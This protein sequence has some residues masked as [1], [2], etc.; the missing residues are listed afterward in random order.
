MKRFRIA[1]IYWIVALTLFTPCAV[2]AYIDPATTTYI[3][4]IITALVVTIGV[5]LSVFLY[6]FRMISS[7]IR[8]GIYG[9]FN[10]RRIDRAPKSLSPVGN[11]DKEE[12]LVGYIFPE[13]AIPGA[14]NPPTVEAMEAL[15]EPTDM[16]KADKKETRHEPEKGNYRKRLL[17]A[18]P[19]SAAIALSFV[20][21]S[22]MDLV[23]ENP[24]DI[25]FKLSAILPTLILVTLVCFAVLLF[26]IPL[27]R[28]WLYLIVVSVAVAILISGYIQGNF[29]NRGLNELTGDA[30]DWGLQK[31]LTVESVIFWV[32][33]LV[34]ILLLAHFLKPAMRVLYI[35]I[36]ILLIIIQTAGLISLG[37]SKT[38]EQGWNVAMFWNQAQEMLTIDG[39][40]N[41]A[42]EK[43][44]IVFVLDRFDENIVS[45]ITA[46]DPHF[47]D[48][49]DGFTMFDDN[50][51][52]AASTFPSVAGMLTGNIYRWDQSDTDYFKY[53]W[54]NAD[55]MHKLV[56][57]GVD[58]RL[59]MDFGYAYND[60]AQ[61]KGIASN[62]ME[63]SIGIN[64]RIALVK[65][66]K[67]TAFR[68][69]PMPA[70]PY[71]WISPT[72]FSDAIA[73]TDKTSPYIS[74]D[75]AFY[76]NIT[77]Y[78]LSPSSAKS[79]FI[80][81][82]LQGPHG[83]LN[84]DENMQRVELST[85]EK[86]AMGSMKIVYEYM[87]QLKALGLYDD[88]TIIITAD[89]GVYSPG[90]LAGPVHAILFVKPAG[91]SGTPLAYSHAP[92]SPAQLPGTVMEGLFGD[93]EGFAPG[94]LDIKDGSEMNREY[95]SRRYLY[96]ITGDGRDFANWHLSGEYS[97][98]WEGKV[99]R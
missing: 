65:L 81:Y 27:F 9:L 77:T 73:L 57:D 5:S 70:K 95:E 12:N 22:C 45:G 87:R 78:G 56:D 61:L 39:L 80:Y 89:H 62:I 13:Y 15:G 59:Y 92:V 79:A 2:Y 63:G 67:L 71:F 68:Y 72:E 18:L 14:E 40:H 35:F 98:Q 88:A 58:V 54:A 85:P 21:F 48:K 51:T 38:S 64:N 55:L 3:I 86:Q 97:D 36:P 49:L 99:P 31:T 10:R 74:N 52:Y 41:P 91:S 46:E 33:I 44:A 17:F 11:D 82:H 60:S 69:A 53:A 24:A 94:Y 96:E 50:I 42:S 30:I 28:R 32:A 84:M 29:L 16:E 66:L 75:F 90:E 20:L 4:Q 83:P 25:P 76:D 26:V 1:L 47:F 43:N 34:V 8:Y 19:V 37:T 7:K 6:R 93:T 23:I